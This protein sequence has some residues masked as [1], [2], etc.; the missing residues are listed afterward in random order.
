M[1]CRRL[2]YNNDVVDNARQRVMIVAIWTTQ[3][4]DCNME[5]STEWCK[6]SVA[7]G[8]GEVVACYLR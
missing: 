7:D 6:D 1:G 8:D 5:K 2:L 4:D 3:C